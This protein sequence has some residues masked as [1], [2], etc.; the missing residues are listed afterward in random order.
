MTIGTIALIIFIAALIGALIVG[1]NHV[2]RN[3]TDFG[4]DE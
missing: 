1:L 3:V 2:A 4:D